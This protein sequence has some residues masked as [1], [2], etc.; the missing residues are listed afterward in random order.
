ML[1]VRALLPDG[2]LVPDG[3]LLLGL[4]IAS[5]ARSLPSRAIDTPVRL[6]GP[7]NVSTCSARAGSQSVAC[8]PQLRKYPVNQ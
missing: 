3:A 8:G 5:S 2:A 4:S 1:P 7:W 6:P